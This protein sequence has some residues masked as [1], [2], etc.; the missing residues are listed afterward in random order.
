MGSFLSYYIISALTVASPGSAVIFT[1]TNTITKGRLAAIR[2]FVGVAL[3]ILV[4]GYVSHEILVHIGKQFSQ[5]L[6]W[7]SLF[8]GTYFLWQAIGLFRNKPKKQGTDKVV[9]TELI[10]GVMISLSNPKALLFFTS[11]FP[12]YFN[13]EI[14]YSVFIIAFAVNVLLIHSLYCLGA[15]R[16]KTGSSH[17]DRVWKGITI[18]LYL[19]L[20]VAC[21]WNSGKL[22]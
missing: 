22:L 2:G 13:S 17:Q 7:V 10:S 1:I 14:H 16:F 4:V 9:S 21:F 6:A 8:G 15:S 3:G 11:V 18:A 19:F 12:L 20:S 5:G